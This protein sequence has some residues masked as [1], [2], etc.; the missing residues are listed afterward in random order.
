MNVRV[1]EKRPLESCPSCRQRCARVEAALGGR[2]RVLI[3]YSGTE[4][5][6]RVMVE[7]E[8]EARV[9]EYAE[10]LARELPAQRS[11]GAG[12]MRS[13]RRSSSTR[14]RSLRDA[15]GRGEL[16]PRRG[17]AT[18]AEL[19]G[20][21]AVRLGANEDL[22]P[23]RE[24][25]LRDARRVAR[26]LELRH[27]ADPVAAE[28]SRSTSRPDRVVLARETAARVALRRARS[29]ARRWRGAARER[30]RA[31]RGGDPRVAR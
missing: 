18:L 30:A 16:R 28:A 1:A 15:T 12:L 3:R 4:P 25:D 27:A 19:A 2:G 13:A 5:K 10:E 26:R 8:D 9:R 20:A 17:R 6:A 23:V 7:G 22:Q 31:A 14:C 21:D 29:T 24:N 11:A